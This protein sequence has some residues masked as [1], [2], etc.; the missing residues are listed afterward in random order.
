MLINKNPNSNESDEHYELKCISKYFLYS[1]GYNIIGT[2][3]SM[4]SYDHYLSSY[5]F[6]CDKIVIDCV[7]VKIL[8]IDNF[9]TM[10]IECKV[11]VGDFRMGF[12]C[13][14]NYTYVISPKGVINKN[15]VPDKIGLIEVDLKNYKIENRINKFI[16]SGIEIVK[17][18]NRRNE[19]SKIGLFKIMKSIARRNTIVD[20]YKHGEIKIGK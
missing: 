16:M 1:K 6:K 10:G 4:N 3:V 12:C 9:N 15:L 20:I 19:N 14:N 13:Q 5:G 8:D 11:S 2:E 7:G 18:C 17:K